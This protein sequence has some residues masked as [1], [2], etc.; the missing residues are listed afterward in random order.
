MAETHRTHKE[1]RPIYPMNE[2]T[3][4]PSDARRYVA[5]GT[6]NI[7]RLVSGSADES[8]KKGPL[9]L[10]VKRNGKRFRRALETSDIGEARKRA[11]VLIEM[12]RAEKWDELRGARTRA[13]WAGLPEVYELYEKHTAIKS[14]GK[15]V[16]RLKFLL[17]V[18]GKDPEGSTSQ[19]G[20]H[21]VWEFQQAQLRTAADEIQR[22]RVM[23]SANS[24]LRQAR[25]LF[26]ADVLPAYRGLTLPDLGGFMKAPK[27]RAPKVQ[28]VAPPAAVVARISAEYPALRESDPAAYAG[29]LLGAFLG[30][31]NGEM[32]AAEWDWVEQDGAGAWWLRL[33]TKA[34]WRSKTAVGRNVAIPLG[35]LQ[36]LQAVRGASREGLEGD[37]RFLIP[38]AHPTERNERMFRRLNGW[39]RVMGLDRAH[40][41]KGVYE[42]RKLWGNVRAWEV[43]S[44]QAAR[45][46][47]NSP[48]V[49]EQYYS[50]AGGRVPVE[51]QAPAAVADTQ[52][53]TPAAAGDTHEKA[54]AV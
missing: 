11:K 3:E 4:K 50:D 45:M 9:Y 42:L 13:G 5:S 31:R 27:L 10:L 26:A 19:L 49:M 20:A 1:Q 35:V 8:A 24:V 6:P 17:R 38:G 41:S 22:G 33:Q 7:L 53:D 47:G 46:A 23:V 34:H 2:P 32:K 54:P 52:R 15:N 12:I 18:A 43:G 21:T 48:A 29:F 44:Y 14:A 36:G 25:S 28:Y 30:L 39:L 40:F 51:I 16:Q 37:R